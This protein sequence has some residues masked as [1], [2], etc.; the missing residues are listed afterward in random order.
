MVPTVTP[1]GDGVP[2][3]YC[4]ITLIALCW[5]VFLMRIGVRVW[6]KAWGVDDWLMLV[7]LNIFTV[8]SGLCIVCCYY[9]SGQFAIDLPPATM[10]KGIKMF[11]INEYFYCTGA[12]FIKCSIAVTLL[13]ISSAHSNP[14][15]T[16]AIWAVLVATWIAAIVFIAGIANICYPIQTLWYEASGTCNLKLN[17]DVSYFFSAV[18]IVTDWSLALLPAVLLWNVKMKGN[19]KASVAVMLALASFASCATI[20]RLKYLTL[21]SDPGE[22]M[23][24]TGKIGFWSL[25]EEGIGIIAASLPAL[26]PL[27]TLRV[28][29]S[30]SAAGSTAGIPSSKTYEARHK[31]AP[32]AGIVMDTFHTL[33]DHD[34]NMSDGDSQ[35]NI[36]KETRYTV[37]SSAASGLGGDRKYN[38]ADH[39]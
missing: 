32:R 29:I 21:Y 1:A 30:S 34:D 4:S 7:G 35:K 17:S 33:G 14:F 19:V 3:L 10:A 8:T 37:T 38:N 6:R 13:R 28:K 36:I 31:P 24:S 15:I 16:W 18:E 22:F 27:L 9:G 5:I 20:V 2:L 39:V 25:I 23:Y 26:K 11:Y 12:M